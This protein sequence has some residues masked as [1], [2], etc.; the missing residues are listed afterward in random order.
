[1]AT[2]G[3]AGCQTNAADSSGLASRSPFD[4]ARAAVRA[5]E[6]GD[7]TAVHALVDLLED[8]DA[9]VRMYSIRALRRL[10]NEDFGYRYHASAAARANA[11][12]S[13]RA[14]LRDGQVRLRQ[15]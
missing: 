2:V 13:W 10:C 5:A 1:M 12:E 7:A 11:V 4:R 14:A 15:P 8:E 3:I 9:A 6:S